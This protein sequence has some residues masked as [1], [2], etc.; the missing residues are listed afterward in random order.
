M[1]SAVIRRH[2]AVAVA[3]AAA[4]VLAACGGDDGGSSATTAG[5]AETTAATAGSSTTAGGG[6]T[7]AATTATT[8]APSTTAKPAATGWAADVA[9]CPKEA[10]TPWAGDTIKIG[11]TL[12]LSGPFA[13]YA[14]L[15][16]GIEAAFAEA[17]AANGIGGKKL[18]LVKKDDGYDPGKTPAAVKELLESDKVF[19]LSGMLG[20]PNVQAVR[21]D[22]NDEC[23]PQLWAA[24]GSSLWGDAENFPWT[25]G[26]LVPYSAETAAYMKYFAGVKPGGTVALLVINNE[27][28]KE[29]ANG[30]KDGATA[31]GL[32]VTTTETVEATDTEVATQMTNLANG[33]ADAVAIAVGPTQCGKAMQSVAE[34]GWKPQ[35]F[36]TQNCANSALFFNPVGAAAE[37]VITSQ[38]LKVLGRPDAEADAGVKA[39]IAALTAADPK[40]S[41]LGIAP[42]GYQV[43]QLTIATL[44]AAAASPGGLTRESV[45]NAARNLKGVTT[46]LLR[47]GMTMN[48]GKGDYFAPEATQLLKYD[49]AAKV[50]QD[51]QSPIDFEG[52]T[53]VLSNT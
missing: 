6:A 44:K 25:T 9:D 53:K 45:I 40:A 35:V 48:M 30:I 17:N 36:L 10:T 51:F 49:S 5:G 8:A 7:T 12:P 43:G 2:Q 3:M 34:S 24:T 50:L 37:G 4:V 23:V 42:T 31:N 38:N 29:F 21:E 47:T 27:Y 18:E 14:P 28:G 39:F 41:P 15:G 46:N 32:K 52:K 33:K 19:F 20:T 13:I 26:A 11:V 1:K 22:L 16:A